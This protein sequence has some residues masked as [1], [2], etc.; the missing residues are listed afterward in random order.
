MTINSELATSPLLPLQEFTESQKL[1]KGFSA[2]FQSLLYS[3]GVILLILADLLSLGFCVWLAYHSRLWL[4]PLLPPE[5]IGLKNIWLLLLL[6]FLIVAGYALRGLYPGYGIPP[7]ERINREFWTTIYVFLTLSLYDFLNLGLSQARGVYALALLII[8]LARP[9]IFGFEI[10]LLKKFRVWGVPVVIIGSSKI[11]KI[12]STNLCSS[13]EIGLIP[14]GFL[15]KIHSQKKP[16]L[17]EEKNGDVSIIGTLSDANSYASRGVTHAIVAESDLPAGILEKIVTGLPF[18]K[19]FIVTNLLDFATHGVSI[20]ELGGLLTIHYNRRLSKQSYHLLK[21]LIDLIIAVP[22]FFVSLPVLL[23]AGLA[24]KVASP[25]PILYTQV[26]AGQGQRPIRV[27]K[28]RT[29]Y[30]DAEERLKQMLATDPVAAQEWHNT[31]KLRRDPRIIKNVGNFLRRT[32]IDELPQLWNIIRGDMSLVGPRPFPLYHLSKFTPEFQQLRSSVKPGL[33]G[34]WQIMA[35]SD[36]NLQI[37]QLLDRYYIL[38]CSL[39]L[40]W[41]ILVRT[42]ISVFTGKGAY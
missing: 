2:R 31:Y 8:L 18:R 16:E 41:Y 25:G 6:P 33:T 32:S 37:Q 14:I 39:W 34:Y 4:Q 27:I 12:L 3:K 36:S 13:P 5:Q 28:L 26:R 9:V 1:Y 17:Q 38:N 30:V 40:D 15:D 11:G 19:V 24:I 29:M 42:F 35:R 20:R 21:R 7:A 22:A 23:L 10:R